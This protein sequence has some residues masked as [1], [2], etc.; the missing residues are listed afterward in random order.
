MKLTYDRNEFD[1]ICAAVFLKA[2]YQS[3]GS[4]PPDRQKFLSEMSLCA[5]DYVWVLSK[6]AYAHGFMDGKD[7][8]NLLNEGLKHAENDKDFF[9]NV[10]KMMVKNE[11]RG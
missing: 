2:W 9:D 7:E 1:N 11:K 3:E 4:N 6:L 8:F 10:I 5:F